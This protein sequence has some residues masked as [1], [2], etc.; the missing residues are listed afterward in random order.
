MTTDIYELF[1]GLDLSVNRWGVVAMDRAGVVHDWRYMTSLKK[2]VGPHS[3]SVPVKQKN[4]DRD[5]FGASRRS[6]VAS[7]V[8]GLIYE[9]LPQ[10]MVNIEHY[11]YAAR[12][13]THQIAEVGGIVRDGLWVNEIPY[14]ETD[15]QSV[16][17]W[18]GRG[19]NCTKLARVQEAQQRNCPVPLELWGSR[20]NG[21]G[22]LDGPA[23]DIADAFF[24]ADMLR[25][26][27]LLREGKVRLDE[28]AQY[29]RN[30]I[31]RVT[32]ANP[33]GLLNR[34]FIYRRD[35]YE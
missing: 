5:S 10:C 32:K 17:M 28:L 3:E 6:T 19:G 33:V 34:P 12:G 18:S 11:A 22:D 4:E 35:V 27:V 7:L 20:K 1:V 16:Q 26:E 2:Y 8:L 29:E 25:V 30:V 13:F 24:L 9:W 14:R 23:T 15:P 21:T 31:N